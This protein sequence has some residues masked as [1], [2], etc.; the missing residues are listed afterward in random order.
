M[1]AVWTS[2]VGGADDHEV[3]VQAYNDTVSKGSLRTLRNREWL[4]DEVCY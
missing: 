3:A 1:D 4:G 2:A